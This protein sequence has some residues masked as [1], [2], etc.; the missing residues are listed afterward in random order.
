MISPPCS[1]HFQLRLAGFDVAEENNFNFKQH[2][3]KV[4]DDMSK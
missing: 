2:G 3:N 1:A 4:V